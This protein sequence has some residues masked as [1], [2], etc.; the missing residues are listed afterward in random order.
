MNDINIEQFRN[1]IRESTALNN[2]TGSVDELMER[3]LTGMTTL[4]DIH[5]PLLHRVITPRPNALW[6]TN[7]VGDAKR[8]RR[9][10]ERKWRHS[11]SEVDRLLY[12]R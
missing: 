3:Y 6:Y 2:I 7:R 4:V 11:K 12:R 5:A 1:D 9:S 8:L 10:Y